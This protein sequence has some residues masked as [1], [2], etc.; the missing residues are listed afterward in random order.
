MASHA[1]FDNSRRKRFVH[2]INCADFESAR[3]VLS[4]G[5]AG[6]ENDWDF[7]R[8]GLRFEPHADFVAIHLRHHYIK[9]DKIRLLFGAGQR[10]GLWAVRGYFCFVRI[11]ECPRDNPD[12]CRRVINNQDELLGYDRLLRYGGHRFTPRSARDAPKSSKAS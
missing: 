9:E 8:G 4:A 6:E 5:L 1:S 12:V 3:F 10:E 7:A 2:V 11:P